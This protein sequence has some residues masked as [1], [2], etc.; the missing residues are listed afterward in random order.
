M[1]DATVVGFSMGG[2]EV[3]RYMS[4][5]GGARVSKAVLVSAVTPYLLQAEDNPDG[6]PRSVFDEIVD[7]LKQDRPHFLAGFGKKFFGAGC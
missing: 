1:H 3:A 7:G 6:V 2:G 4:R 5:H